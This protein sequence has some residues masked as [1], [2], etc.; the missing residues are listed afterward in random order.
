M[1]LRIGKQACSIN[2]SSLE[3]ECSTTQGIRK[4]TSLTA[5]RSKR[6]D[7]TRARVKCSYL[8]GCGGEEGRREMGWGWEK[9]GFTEVT[10]HRNLGF[11]M[12]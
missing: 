8:G 9:T 1:P 11:C 12:R 7:A 6:N 4:A 10:E 5:G 2:F 3:L